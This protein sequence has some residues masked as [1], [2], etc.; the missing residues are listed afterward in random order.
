MQ[1]P[2]IDYEGYDYTDNRNEKNSNTNNETISLETIQ[3]PYYD[4]NEY[5]M[6]HGKSRTK[7]ETSEKVDT[8]KIV[9]NVYY[10]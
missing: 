8:I 1:L 6:I 3:N 5:L 9:N 10:E 7:L 2:E 4:E